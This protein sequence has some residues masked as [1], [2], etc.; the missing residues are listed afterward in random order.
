[1]SLTM[2]DPLFPAQNPLKAVVAVI[3]VRQQTLVFTSELSTKACLNMLVA[4]RFR[5]ATM[6]NQIR[7]EQ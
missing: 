1:M 4:V 7:A 2:P 6:A 3:N 5:K